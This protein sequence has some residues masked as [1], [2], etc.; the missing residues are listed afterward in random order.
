MQ[1]GAN[2]AI[3]ITQ[4]DVNRMKPTLDDLR[5][6]KIFT[7]ADDQVE[8]MIVAM[9]GSRVDVKADT[10]GKWMLTQDTPTS[11]TALDQARLNQLKDD[12][13]A[14]KATKFL[15]ANTT[16]SETGLDRPFV[17]VPLAGKDG[18]TSQTISTGHNSK[19]GDFVYARLAGSPQ[20]LGINTSEPRKFFLSPDQ[21]VDKR[22][23]NIDEN[24]VKKVQV[25]DGAKTITFTSE[26]S[27]AWSAK[28]DGAVKEFQVEGSKMLSLILSVGALE[29]TK[30]LDPRVPTEKAII[31]RNKLD[32]PTREVVLLDESGKPFARLG[33][34][35]EENNNT[36]V[37]RDGKDHFSI[38]SITYNPVKNALEEVLK[39]G[40]P[41]K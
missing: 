41:K 10:A 35:A 11:K 33:Q 28:P 27:G 3:T 40:E 17:T 39:A 37:L 4:D 9:N 7:L 20:L 36:F 24:Q 15:D 34:A 14:L 38:K 26:P 16:P 18:K 29:W 13:L 12:L 30:R 22:M 8:R 21:I 32:A 6:K 1:Q 23:F 25:R 19:E 31:E 5:S 2:Y